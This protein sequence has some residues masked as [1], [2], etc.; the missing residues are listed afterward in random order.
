MTTTHT[1]HFTVDPHIIIDLIF[2]QAGSVE[3]AILELVMNEID[4]KATTTPKKKNN[5]NVTL[6]AL[7]WGADRFSHSVALT[8]K[9]MNSA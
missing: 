1:K 6:G 8:G 4:A 3:K 9:R 7:A 2:Q 5:A